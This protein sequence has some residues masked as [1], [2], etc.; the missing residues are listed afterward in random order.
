[1]DPTSGPINRSPIASSSANKTNGIAPL[2]V[3]FSSA[4]SSDPEG[5]NLTYNWSFGDGA[6]S[7][8]ANPSHSY[9]SD[10]TFTVRLT[11]SDGTNSATAPD[12]VIAVGNQA[13]TATAGANTLSGPPPLAVTFSS[14]GSSDPE[15][16]TLT[17]SWNFGDGGTSTL[18][19]PS[20][21]YSTLGTYP[22]TLTVSDGNKTGIASLTV[23]VANQASALIA[24][25][26]LDV[27]S[28]TAVFDNSGH[29]V[30]G[31]VNGATWSA[32][33]KYL[34]GLAFNGLSD[35]VE[36][37]NPAALQLTGSM[38]L[39]AW[40]MAT[41][42]PADDGQIIAKSDATGW[43]LKTSPDTGVRTFGI[44]LSDGTGARVQRY[45]QTTVSLNTWYHVAGVYNATARTLDMYVNGV[46]NNGVLSG[47]VPSAQVDSGAT[48]A[49]GRREGGYFFI[50]KLDE[51]RVYGRALTA[52][53]IARDMNNPIPKPP[54][55]PSVVAQ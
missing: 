42:N 18:A 7:T 13:P 47:S 12:I 50:G 25:Y 30:A 23:T 21:T 22:V 34:G 51:V 49:I 8:A 37:G 28:G 6:T 1:V 24:A 43:Q 35:Y 29:G 46:L 38:T 40:V 14:A 32:S 16:A 55:A 53:E 36:L 26:G 44:A 9:A 39:E 54:G 17:Y 10:G 19:N 15:G 3:S 48:A 52:S 11:V 31:V 33:G 45:S 41:G 20:H 27:G 4:G 2:S 5:A